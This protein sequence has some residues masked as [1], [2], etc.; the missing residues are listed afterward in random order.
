M[1]CIEIR[2]KCKGQ[3]K[4]WKILIFTK[5]GCGNMQKQISWG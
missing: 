2:F 3:Q 5:N 1:L 4:T